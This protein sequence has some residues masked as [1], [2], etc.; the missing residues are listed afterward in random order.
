MISVWRKCSFSHWIINV[1][2]RNTQTALKTIFSLLNVNA[3]ESKFSLSNK[4]NLV[5]HRCTTQQ[6]YWWFYVIHA[7]IPIHGYRASGLCSGYTQ[8]RFG[9]VWYI[10]SRDDIGQVTSSVWFPPG[11]TLVIQSSIFVSFVSHGLRV[12][13]VGTF[14]QRPAV[15]C[16]LL[17][18]GFC[19]ATLPCRSDW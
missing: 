8:Q 10:T 16:L 5:P 6:L 13:Q 3:D 7:P 1:A 19:L 14:W 18:C 15:M 2:K 11:M 9:I 4:H 12:F 17:R